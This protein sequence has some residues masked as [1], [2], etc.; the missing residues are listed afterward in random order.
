MIA[1]IGGGIFGLSIGWNLVRAA[2]PVTIFDQGRV[3]RGATWAA[4]GMLMP[5]KLSSIFSPDLFA[6]QRES[7][8]MWPDFA[9]E[10]STTAR[11][12]LE[13][14][15]EGRYFLALSD[16]AQKRLYK[17]YDFHRQI[18]FALEWLSADELRAREP[19]V[20][21]KVQA[22]VFSSMGHWIDTRQ[23]AEALR[24][25]F[26]RDGGILREQT[27]VSEVVHANG[28]VRG[29]RAKGEL[30]KAGTVIVAAGAW[31]R[32]IAGLPEPLQLAV[33]PVKGQ[34]VTL[35]MPQNDP[36][37]R[38]PMIGPVYLVPRAN[39]RLIVGTTVEREAG[40][41][42]QP[43]VSGVLQI[44][45]RA[46]DVLPAVVQLP[47]VE[48]GAGLRPTGPDRLPVLGKTSIA[49]LLAATGGHSYGIL[50][51]PAVARSMTKLVLS[52]VTPLLIQPFAP[53]NMV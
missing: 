32:Q 30:F 49:G 45:N 13:Y 38:Q 14:H 4:A 28:R 46:Q 21:P 24:S 44:L 26:L 16:Q 35:Q 34:L 6:L 41:D 7:H 27:A 36:L 18:G 33:R 47:I 2:Q 25:A 17:Q 15:Q 31:S 11:A 19:H 42:T 3:G 48:V 37:I 23:L 10:V 40:F 1:I 22:A 8:Q 52:G 29:V 12:M 43:T 51:A 20:G 50:L 53:E 5:W 9:A 39:G